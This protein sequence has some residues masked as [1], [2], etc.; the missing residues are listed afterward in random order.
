MIQEQTLYRYLYETLV[1]KIKSGEFHQIRKLPSQK[2]LCKQYN[3]GITT[4]RRV[5]QLLQK[6]GYIQCESGQPAAVVYTASEMEYAA[7]L[8]ARKEEI[9]DAFQ[10]LGLLLPQL[11]REAV[12]YVRE[13][14][15]A[16][17]RRAIDEIQEDM[18]THLLYR[19]SNLFLTTLIQVFNNPLLMDLELDSENFLH[20]PYLPFAHHTDPFY[21]TPSHMKSWL[22]SV[23]DC[24]QNNQEEL[25]YTK[26]A[27]TY[28]HSSCRV[29]AYLEALE[30]QL[31]FVPAESE[32]S[33]RWFHIKDR[34]ELY[35][36]LAMRILRRIRKKEFSEQKYIPSIPRIMKEYG[37]MKETASRCI[38]LLNSLGIT[39]TL[40]KKG[41]IVLPDAPQMQSGRNNLNDPIIKQRILYCLD[42]LQL[43]AVSL[44]CGIPF[45]M[46][47]V[48]VFSR[49]LQD[50]LQNASFDKKYALIIQ[51]SMD[52]IIQSVPTHSLK[53]IF[54]QLN[55]LLVWGYYLE[56]VDEAFYSDS[57]ETQEAVQRLL[58]E[59]EKETVENTSA[60]LQ[61]VFL[62]IYRDIY[63]VILRLPY[64]FTPMPLLL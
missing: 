12:K 32:K 13:S 55:D 37:V 34:S 60:A 14:D 1:R 35:A 49:D 16:T 2:Q 58:N 61:C 11:Y 53:N 52:F 42:A 9:N 31:D 54:L 20:V 3:V 17:M 40:N 33:I 29:I 21:R 26:I 25:L 6:E 62:Q 41:T 57:K 15:K 45:D 7:A 23:F 47:E 64:N 51:L 18:P 22:S 5:M 46:A 27:S 30:K 44:H 59:L 28:Q 19:Q 50:V 48:K 8:I 24:I 36:H 39:R 56:P 38:A 4:V 63:H 43:L 10:G